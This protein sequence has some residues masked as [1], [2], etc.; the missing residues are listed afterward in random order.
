MLINARSRNRKPSTCRGVTISKLSRGIKLPRFTLHEGEE[1]ELPQ[2]RY[3]ADGS[4]E[5][6]G[7]F[8]DLTETMRSS[9]QRGQPGCLVTSSATTAHLT[10]RQAARSVLECFTRLHPPKSSRSTPSP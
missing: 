4:A 5:L 2:S 6:G 1:W 3:Q 10:G 8:T 7:G 9:L